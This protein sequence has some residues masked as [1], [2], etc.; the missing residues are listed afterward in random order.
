MSVQSEG[1]KVHKATIKVNITETILK[2]IFLGLYIL[3]L[4]LAVVLAE[5]N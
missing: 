5:I 2:K 3:A 4:F 1:K